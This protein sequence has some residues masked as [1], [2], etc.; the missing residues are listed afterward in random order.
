MKQ[1]SIAFATLVVAIMASCGNGTPKPSFKNEIDT[2]SY[3]IGMANSQGLKNYLVRAKNVDTTYMDEFIRGLNDAVNAGNNK[4]RTAYYAGLEIGQQVT[5]QI[6]AGI[7]FDLFGNDSTETINTK[8]FIAGFVSGTL[9]QGGLMT[10]EESQQVAQELLSVVKAKQMEKIYG[11]WKKQNEDFIA[12]IAKQPG[13]KKLSDGVYYE[14]LEEGTGE[15]PADTSRVE[16]DYEGKLITDSIFDSSY[17]RGEPTKFLCSQVVPGW[18]EAL[19]NMPVGSKW[20]VYIASDKAYGER[21]SGAIQPFSALVFTIDLK[22]IVNNK[23][24]AQ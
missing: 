5:Q 13:V 15:I 11:E 19:T 7:N 2:L 12:Q 14:V 8:N 20:K 23:A 4:K 10:L 9:E 18:R 24:N 1:L 17:K 22:D 21:G 6:I 3:A 16:V